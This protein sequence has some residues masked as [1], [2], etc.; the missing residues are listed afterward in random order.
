MNC[1]L[2]SLLSITLLVAL[3]GSVASA[4]LRVT[5]VDE[6]ISTMTETPAGDTL[7]EGSH[8]V[9][10]APKGQSSIFSKLGMVGGGIGALLGSA[11]DNS[12]AQTAAKESAGN[13]IDRLKLKWFNELNAAL[14]KL[15]TDE[16]DQFKLT[17]GTQ[18]D[19]GAKLRVY[20]RLSQ[21][22]TEGEFSAMLAV[23]ARF[24]DADDKDVRRE[25]SHVLMP[26]RAV[27]G[28]NSWTAE[29][30]TSLR[31]S[32]DVAIT[33]L[34]RVIAKDLQGMYGAKRV[35][36]DLPTLSWK[37]PIAEQA[38]T[39]FIVDETGDAYVVHPS[40]RG[41]PLRALLAILEKSLVKKEN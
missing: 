41:K 3:W 6:E 10:A 26:A 29:G 22:K 1:R 16:P 19:P 23:K 35:A 21:T 28:D 34:A 33:R 25:Y 32:T 20:A 11:I 36:E 4:Q 30:P 2:P 7:L 9:L 27:S 31:A 13:A 15:S 14:K 39:Y 40:F 38:I 17:I 24:K 5:A 18:D 12:R 8:V 37:P